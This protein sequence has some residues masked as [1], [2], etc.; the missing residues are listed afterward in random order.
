MK[1]IQNLLAVFLSLLLCLSLTSTARADTYSVESITAKLESVLAEYPH[2]STWTDSFDGGKQCY[3]FAK[4]VVYK[5]FGKYTDSK[6]RSWLYNGNSSSGMVKIDAVENC[7][8]TN[9]QTLLQKALPGDVLQFDTG[10]T[11]GHQH[12]MIVYSVISNGAEIYECNWTKNTVTKT[13][14]TSA[15]IANRQTRSD[16]TKRGTLSL[17]RSDNYPTVDS[18]VQA[19]LNQCTS[20]SC[21][22]ILTVTTAGNMKNMPCSVSTNAQSQTVETLTTGDKYTSTR[23]WSNTGGSHWYEVTSKSGQRGFIYAGDVSIDNTPS[24]MHVEGNE[25]G[26]PSGKLTKGASFGLRGIIS[27]N[28][29]IYSVEA[30]IYD[31][32]PNGHDAIP[33][34]RATGLNVTSYNIKDDG[35]NNHFSFSSLP[36]GEYRYMVFA[37]DTSMAASKIL[38]D[39]HF[40]IGTVTYTISYNA[41][42]GTGAPSSQTKTYGTNLTLSSTKPTRANSNAGSYTVTLNANGGSVNTS[43]LSAA[44]TT[45]Y[46]FK[47][48]NTAANGSG[49]NYNAGATYTPNASSTLYAQWNSSTSTAAVTL[50]TPTRTGYTFKGWGTSST[51]SSGVTGKYTPSG[52]VTLYA[53]WE[54]NKYTVSYNAN[55]GTGAPANQTKTH[56][57]NLTLSSTKPTRANSSAESYTVTLNTNGGSVSAT[58]LDAARTT[59][60]TFKNW[61]TKQD[62]SGTSYN[63]GASYTANE[64]ATLYAQWNS[65]ISTSSVTLPTPTR[66][67]YT[68]KGWGTSSTATSGVTG[69]YTPTGN[70]TLYA[71]WEAN[72]Y[73]VTYNANGGTGAPDSQSKTFNQALTLSK[74]TPTRDGFFFIGWAETANANSAAY[75][76]GGSFTK[77]ADVT[78]YAVWIKPDLTLP[79]ALTTIESEAFAGGGF[80]SVLIPPTVKEIASDAF[81]DRTDLIILGTSGSFAETFAGEKHFTFVPAA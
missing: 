25:A 27:S 32:D 6:Y 21:N 77:N 42:G 71:V 67:G 15:Q 14:L 19:Y 63:A 36:E 62:G 57:T 18:S 75:Q 30:H 44:R 7:T 53:I 45:S 49:T 22:V 3:G 8:S 50:P 38:I 12:S 78:L 61:N 73:T 29:P 74:A 5:L 54:A 65:S 4:L 43:S 2:G 10:N 39:S 34:Y 28:Y 47:N 58:S 17:L 55:G 51:A 23:R 56:G 68:F 1:I 81:G 52:N 66:T 20:T 24:T 35:I 48:W 80:N 16:G 70:V 11:S 41:N 69:N 40:T 37:R 13:N 79:A 9:V 76:P 31:S 46:T 64:A 72:N 60:Y 26:T 33:A 59:S